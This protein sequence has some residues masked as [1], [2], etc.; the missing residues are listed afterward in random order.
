MTYEAE[1]ITTLFYKYLA[2]MKARSLKWT[3]KGE[4]RRGDKRILKFIKYFCLPIEVSETI[5]LLDTTLFRTCKEGYLFTTSGIIIKETMN[6]LYYL[7]FADIEQAE[8]QEL[9]DEGYNLITSIW[10]HFK[11]GTKRQ[12]MDYYINKYSIVDYINSAI[13]LLGQPYTEEFQENEAEEK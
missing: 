12:M 11:D 5:A 2:T 9:R 6:K 4:T 7:K 13:E 10:V 3:L 8:V 1:K